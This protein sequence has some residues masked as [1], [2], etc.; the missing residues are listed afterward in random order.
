MTAA[1][2]LPNAEAV[3]I[4]QEKISGYLLCLSHPVGSS[5][6]RFF[7]GFG[8]TPDAWEIFA[9]ALKQICL[10]SNVVEFERTAFGTR[11]VIDG[12]LLSPDGR[13]PVVRTVWFIDTGR[14]IPHLVTAH[15]LPSLKEV[16]K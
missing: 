7:R 14:E 6:A 13:N 3:L 2:R 15:P 5:K 4:Q 16:K 10:T 12:V 1:T 8:F 9:H 11:F